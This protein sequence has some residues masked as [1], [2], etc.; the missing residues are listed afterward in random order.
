M[1]IWFYFCLFCSNNI[2]HVILITLNKS[3]KFLIFQNFKYRNKILQAKMQFYWTL[4]LISISTYNFSKARWTYI[5]FLFSIIWISNRNPLFMFSSIA[6]KDTGL[7]T[8]AYSQIFPQFLILEF[9][10]R[11]FQI[12]QHFPTL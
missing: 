6:Q 10:S 7:I 1:F 5:N 12:L 11:H 8:Q 9:Q 4:L 3:G 2:K